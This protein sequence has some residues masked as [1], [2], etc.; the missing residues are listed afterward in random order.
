MNS[1]RGSSK[2]AVVTGGAQ[3]IGKAIS[4]KFAERR[5]NV[6]VVDIDKEAGHELVSGFKKVY[7]IVFRHLDVSKEDS[8]EQLFD[9]IENEYGRLD[10][11]VNNAGLAS[12]DNTPIEDLN[13]EEWHEKIDVNLSGP[14]LCTKYAVR[15]LR[16]S[17]GAVVNI[18]SIRALMSEPNN[19]AYSASKGGVIA[20]THA[21]ANSLGPDIRVNAISPGWIDVR[22][23]QKRS[24][25]DARPL[26][27]TAHSQH[28]VGRVGQPSDIADMVSYLISNRAGFIT[29][30]N[31]V[32][33]G[34]MV[35][36][37][38]YQ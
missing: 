34:G 2:V 1:E 36:K 12:P 22:N 35:R 24:K 13:S 33:D 14:M 9:F 32:V 28:P 31:F 29:G 8:V 21:L 30:Q 10:A 37:E 20:L 26:S 27:E 17:K 3:G 38:V 4:L 6:I 16:K 23:W 5:W 11:L 25:R 7:S 15:L 19:E 18:A